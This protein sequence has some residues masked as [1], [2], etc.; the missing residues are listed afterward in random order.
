[1]VV[2]FPAPLC[3]SSALTCPG[4]NV[5]VRLS[6]AAAPLSNIF[7]NPRI[8]TDAR[9]DCSS[10][11][12]SKL[13]PL[14]RRRR[15]RPCHRRRGARRTSTFAKGNH[16]GRL[17]VPPGHTIEIPRRGAVDDESRKV[18]PMTPHAE[19]SPN[20]LRRADPDAKV[21]PSWRA[22]DARGCRP[23]G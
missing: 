11:K 4:T 16:G 19:N 17:T 10:D 2:V 14:S 13:S 20:L 6:T 3:P 23:T 1:M 12:G 7:R 22:R 15:R 9:L 18:I 8:F 21:M 5:A